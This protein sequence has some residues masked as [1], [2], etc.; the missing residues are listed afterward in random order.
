[1]SAIPR[2][3]K[4]LRIANLEALAEDVEFDNPEQ[5]LTALL[6]LAVEQR[7]ANRVQRLIQQARFPPMDMSRAY[8]YENI[9][10]PDGLDADELMTLEF[11][12]Q[13][14][15]LCFFGPCGTGKT[16]LAVMLGLKACQKGYSVQFYRTVDLVNMLVEAYEKGRA[17]TALAAIAKCHMLVLDEIGYIPFSKRAA[18]M[19]FSVVSQGY[20]RQTIVTTSNLEFG[21]WNEIFGDDRLTAALIDRIV[22]RSNI[23]GFTGPSRR[24]EEAMAKRSPKSTGSTTK[25]EEE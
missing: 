5:Y 17:K 3:C 1:M 8:S 15:N 2:L 22:H 7:S 10:F 21:R 4:T 12:E 18:E 25:N 16:R 24:F 14:E 23:L 9:S 11:L 20:Q 13:K 6:E 19:L